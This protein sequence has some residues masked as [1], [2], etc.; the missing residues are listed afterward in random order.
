MHPIIETM[1]D[2]RRPAVTHFGAHLGHPP[3]IFDVTPM[4]WRI[5]AVIV[6]APQS[7]VGVQNALLRWLGE[8]SA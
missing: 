5:D 2:V 7:A 8:F 6:I 4:P 1:L 3:L